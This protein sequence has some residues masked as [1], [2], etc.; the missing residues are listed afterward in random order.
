M[1]S[2]ERKMANSLEYVVEICKRGRLQTENHV[3]VWRRKKKALCHKINRD[4][5]KKGSG[6]VWVR[7]I[8]RNEGR[9]SPREKKKPEERE[10][11]VGQV[12]C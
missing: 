10:S 6:R 11:R 4:F 12:K 8:L 1:A 2:V 9:W 5:N 7:K 3:S